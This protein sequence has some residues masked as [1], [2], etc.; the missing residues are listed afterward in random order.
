[1]FRVA[2]IKQISFAPLR[3]CLYY[4]NERFLVTV[5]GSTHDTMRDRGR[6]RVRNEGAAVGPL[7]VGRSVGGDVEGAAEGM[8]VCTAQH[9]VVQLGVC[10]GR[11]RR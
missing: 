2:P 6:S 1:M 3:V 4:R 7:S 9:G 5:E 11:L 10:R 8:A